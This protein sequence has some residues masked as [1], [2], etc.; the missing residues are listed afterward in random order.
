M[1]LYLV[2]S[3][4]YLIVVLHC[5]LYAAKFD[6]YPSSSRDNSLLLLSILVDLGSDSV[7]VSDSNLGEGLTS[8][9][10]VSVF[11]LESDEADE[12]SGFQLL[13][14][15]SDVSTGSSGS[16]FGF[17]SSLFFGSVVGS[18]GG[19][20]YSLSHVKLVGNR[21]SSGV[22]PVLVVWGQI[23]ISSSFSVSDPL[24]NIINLIKY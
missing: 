5:R 10:F 17:S 4:R 13:E 16:S 24:I 7:H 6:S 8:S 15:V 18:E 14:A 20:S 11:T 9:G 21:G 22:E 3:N 12:S 1:R 2:L 19:D 23:L